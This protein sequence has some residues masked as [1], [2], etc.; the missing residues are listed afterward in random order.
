MGK[1][2]DLLKGLNEQL[3]KDMSHAEAADI[4]G[5][6]D[7][8]KVGNN[9]HVEKRGKDFAVKLHETD[10]VTMHPDK[11]YTLN[12]GGWKTGVT[13]D[14]IHAHSPAKIKQEKGEW[15]LVD[16]KGTK[17][18]FVDGMKVDHYGNPIKAEKPAKMKKSEDGLE[19]A[20][21]KHPVITLHGA[22]FHVKTLDSTHAA[23]RMDGTEK[24]GIPQHIAQLSPEAHKQL[25]A[26]GHIST[27]SSGGGSHFV[28]HDEIE[29]SEAPK[30]AA[31]K[32][33]AESYPQLKSE[34]LKKAAPKPMV[35]SYK[36]MKAAEDVKGV[37]AP[38]SAGSGHSMAG[39]LS[40][41]SKHGTPDAKAAVKEH[42]QVLKEIKQ[43]SNA[44]EKSGMGKSEMK[45]GMSYKD[46]KKA[47]SLTKDSLGIL[48]SLNPFSSGT[49]TPPPPPAPAA[50]AGDGSINSRIGN[51]FGK[52]EEAGKLDKTTIVAPA[53]PAAPADGKPKAPAKAP[54]AAKIKT[55]QIPAL[56][57]MT[58]LGIK[59]IAKAEFKP[60][61]SY[62]DMKKSGVHEEFPGKKGQSLAGVETRSSKN[63]TD[64]SARMTTPVSAKRD[65]AQAGH[66][67]ADSAKGGHEKVLAEMKAMPKPKLDKAEPKL[68][69][70]GQSFSQMKK[71]ELGMKVMDFEGTSEID[72]KA[73]IARPEAEKTIEKEA[74][75][76]EAAIFGQN[77][78]VRAP[79]MAKSDVAAKSGPHL[80]S[81]RDFKRENE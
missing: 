12:S 57:G 16:S 80:Q 15:H 31:P 64:L 69:N 77:Q 39:V 32:P 66:V 8:K 67:M 24:W 61:M 10:V 29:K 56:P 62:R 53:A 75:Q 40:A 41:G 71:A 54:D 49:A 55:P 33:T 6:K 81:F 47:E 43:I 37:H 30:V 17:H 63:L 19:K 22:K 70:K 25:S 50:P 26:S 23:M 1:A 28:H 52:G 65:V 27:P 2:L 45:P 18:P 14:R 13:R 21:K 76:K 48:S 78:R 79:E 59:P 73:I 46:M 3:A 58:P 4:V 34:G 7:S 38:L 51:P 60:G 11:T 72:P 44:G 35:Q 68:P 9:T 74:S 5:N 42:R 20:E 36:Q